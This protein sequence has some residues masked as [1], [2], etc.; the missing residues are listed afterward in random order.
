MGCIP[1]KTRTII[2]V[3]VKKFYENQKNEK[4]PSIKIFPGF[5]IKKG[6]GDPY[7]EYELMNYLGEGGYGKVYKVKHKLTGQYRAMKIIK[8]KSSSK[9]HEE[10]IKKEIEI[11]KSL[12]H[13]NI[14]KLYEFFCN[15]KTFFIIN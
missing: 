6:K 7:E 2:E 1:R 15:E 8:C 3:N 14:L 12:D 5:F 11:L 13:P 10:Q 4:N 9:K